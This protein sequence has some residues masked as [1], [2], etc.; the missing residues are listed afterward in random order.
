MFARRG[1]TVSSAP[2]KKQRRR[3]PGIEAIEDAKAGDGGVG[4]GESLSLPNSNGC[5]RSISTVGVDEFPPPAPSL[6]DT[7]VLRLRHV[8]R[9]GMHCGYAL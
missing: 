5:G 1:V 6:Q 8:C 3:P 9:Q 4:E 7:L 2:K